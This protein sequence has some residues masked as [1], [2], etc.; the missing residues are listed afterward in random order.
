[1]RVV[2]N[3]GIEKV[4]VFARARANAH[5][6]IRATACNLYGASR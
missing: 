4:L 2:V 6:Q 5:C 3:G 1:M